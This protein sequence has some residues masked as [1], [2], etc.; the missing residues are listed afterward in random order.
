MAN[1]QG[2]GSNQGT[3]GAQGGGSSSSDSLNELSLLDSKI[4]EAL[5]GG[6]AQKFSAQLQSMDQEIGMYLN[7]KVNAGTDGNNNLQAEV[8]KIKGELKE[9]GQQEGGG[10]VLKDIV[11][12]IKGFA[13]VVGGVMKVASTIG[14]FFGL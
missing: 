9:M 5:N 14:S 11:G 12:G 6:K 3:N 8:D 13:D 2:I 7:G 4:R 1:V 10:D